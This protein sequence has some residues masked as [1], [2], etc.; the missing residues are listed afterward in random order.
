[1]SITDI[2]T[3]P[4][5]EVLADLKSI[6]LNEKI[7][8]MIYQFFMVIGGGAPDGSGFLDSTEIYSDNVWRTIRQKLPIKMGMF[9]GVTINNRVL[10]FG[11]ISKSY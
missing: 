5:L 6:D 9:S 2:H 3:E 1:M 8:S 11:K 4:I 7:Y 10:T